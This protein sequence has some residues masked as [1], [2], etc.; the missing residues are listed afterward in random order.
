MKAKGPYI[1]RCGLVVWYLE[2]D[3]FSRF[4]VD[5]PLGPPWK[6]HW[7]RLL[8]GTPVFPGNL[9]AQHTSKLWRV[10]QRLELW[11]IAEIRAA[12]RAS[13]YNPSDA[14]WWR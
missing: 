8:P 10:K 5:E 9:T 11:M 2:C 13:T 7:C 3:H 12:S 14:E 4:L 1:H 6:C